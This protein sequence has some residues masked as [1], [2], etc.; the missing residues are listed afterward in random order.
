MS[1]FLKTGDFNNDFHSKIMEMGKITGTTDTKF[2]INPDIWVYHEGVPKRL[3]DVLNSK[4]LTLIAFTD[5]ENVKSRLLENLNKFKPHHHNASFNTTLFETITGQYS[6]MAARYLRETQKVNI[7]QVL[8]TTLERAFPDHDVKIMTGQVLNRVNPYLEADW[9]GLTPSTIKDHRQIKSQAYLGDM[10]G[11]ITGFMGGTASE[12]SKVHDVDLDKHIVHLVQLYKKGT[13]KLVDEWVDTKKFP[14]TTHQIGHQRASSAQL[15]KMIQNISKP[16]LNRAESILGDVTKFRTSV[17]GSNFKDAIKV[18]LSEDILGQ[19]ISK[20][21]SFDAYR[22]QGIMQNIPETMT[23]FLGK[24]E[25]IRFYNEITS[26]PAKRAAF[27]YEVAPSLRTGESL[28]VQENL[29]KALHSG[30]ALTAD[31]FSV[32]QSRVAFSE[33][34]KM[35]MFPKRFEQMTNEQRKQY[36]MTLANASPM[37][38]ALLATGANEKT[39]A[40]SFG[41]NPNTKRKPIA[42][43]EVSK[44]PQGRLKVGSADFARRSIIDIMMETSVWD[45]TTGKYH[46]MLEF[47]HMPL[48]GELGL[49][50]NRFQGMFVTMREFTPEGEIAGNRNGLNARI[51][52]LFGGAHHEGR[53]KAAYMYHLVNQQGDLMDRINFMREETERQV[54][55]LFI[56]TDSGKRRI[57]DLSGRFSLERLT[58][59][60]AQPEVQE[61]ARAL[62]KDVRYVNDLI[63]R[64][65]TD[66]GARSILQGALMK[67]DIMHEGDAYLKIFKTI[68]GIVG[69]VGTDVD[70]TR[71]SYGSIKPRSKYQMTRLGSTMV[72]VQDAYLKGQDELAESMGMINDNHSILPFAKSRDSGGRFHLLGMSHRDRTGVPL[73]AD[74]DTFVSP[75]RPMKIS[76]HAHNAINLGEINLAL[77]DLD[78]ASINTALFGDTENFG[79]LGPTV[80]QFWVNEELGERMRTTLGESNHQALSNVQTREYSVPYEY[81]DSNG[82]KVTKFAKKPLNHLGLV[83][84]DVGDIRVVATQMPGQATIRHSKEQIHAMIGI[85]ELLEKHGVVEYMRKLSMHSN[86]S[87]A[88]YKIFEADQSKDNLRRLI[89]TLQFEDVEY[90][91]NE[92]RNTKTFK[93]P[94]LKG[95]NNLFMSTVE[96]SIGSN[97]LQEAGE[98]ADIYLHGQNT[99]S[100]SL[101]DQVATA[102][103]RGNVSMDTLIRHVQQVQLERDPQNQ[104]PEVFNAIIDNL[105]KLSVANG[106]TPSKPTH[107]PE[108][109]AYSQKIMQSQA[110]KNLGFA[111]G[112]AS[113]ILTKVARGLGYRIL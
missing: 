63:R 97:I 83:H 20:V 77:F 65:Q 41:I 6:N 103:Q 25:A 86:D 9:N 29:I 37:E 108:E 99:V 22:A 2:K 11:G 55:N 73:F 113:E 68:Q 100:H 56:D 70:V 58:R 111:E 30:R 85:D 110:A 19:A 10:P 66:P 36:A 27:L 26:D 48:P 79:P 17:T 64:A 69:N 84:S 67:R 1:N 4:S 7:T 43:P 38:R 42:I 12:Y 88:A 87:Y 72:S 31:V 21:W 18:S 8:K 15:D 28:Q 13:G 53:E 75:K 47:E 54:Q 52:P 89:S 61:L 101:M 78:P 98:G 91:Y 46:A 60:S 106:Q 76:A 94:V 49:D 32:L 40:E 35:F 33:I 105:K 44:D 82:N 96:S 5:G 95:A 24:E 81:T 50:P 74:K 80:G 34:D 39:F 90:Q 109:I 93:V 92:G 62:G 45:D 16:D 104:S 57:G 107:R 3:V 112:V 14:Y 102:A 23:P 59:N 51:R 71:S